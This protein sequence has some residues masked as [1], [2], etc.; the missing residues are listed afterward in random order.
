MRARILTSLLLASVCTA[1]LI[2]AP[3]SHVPGSGG[4]SPPPKAA[5]MGPLKLKNGANLEDKV[6]IIDVVIDPGR[7][8]PGEQ[9]QV[10]TRYRVL[11]DMSQDYLIFVHGDDMDGRAP[12][13][14]ADHV[15]V[16]GTRPTSTWRQ[17]EIITD[18][19]VVNVPSGEKI[20]KA[21]N[22]WAG[23]WN[24]PTDSRL[25]LKNVDEVRNDGKN[26]IL[27]G[28]LPVGR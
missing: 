15:P 28:T 13:I 14:N 4:A 24:A 19:F 18:T 20:P 1:C 2:P 9:A 25:T 23:F 5:E 7:A 10:T 12:R 3:G 26:R 21:I 16:N 11:Q 22:I 8:Y 17:G 6:Q 27:L